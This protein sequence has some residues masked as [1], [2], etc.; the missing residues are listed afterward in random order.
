MTSITFFLQ[1]TNL[2]TLHV[3]EPFKVEQQ[4]NIQYQAFNC[5]HQKLFTLFGSK[6]L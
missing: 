6:R 5:L 4:G 3:H 1:K 2:G